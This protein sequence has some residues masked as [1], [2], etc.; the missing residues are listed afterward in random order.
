M[1]TTAL[2]AFL[3]SV[4]V[5][6]TLILITQKERRRGRR[7]FAAGLR[8]WLDNVF[9]RLGL[10]LT[11]GWDHFVRYM[12]RLNWYYSLH[13]LLRAWLRF[14]VAVYTYFEDIFERNRR[15]TKRLRAEKKRLR[16]DSH[17]EQIAKHKTAM[18]LTEAEKRR[19]KQ[20]ELEGKE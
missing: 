10:S 19:L 15:R 17:L 11:R 5:L 8:N 12:I 14:L 18:A 9:D 16:A 7:F 2:I 6:V 3:T 1:P 13:S 20:R 4:A